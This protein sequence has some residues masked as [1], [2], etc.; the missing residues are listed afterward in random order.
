MRLEKS[1]G[2][3]FPDLFPCHFY[4]TRCSQ[5]LVLMTKPS[6]LQSEMTSTDLISYLAPHTSPQRLAAAIGDVRVLSADS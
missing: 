4:N 6:V 3:I 1:L 5:L 2:V